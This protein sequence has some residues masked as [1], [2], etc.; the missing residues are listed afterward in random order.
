VRASIKKTV[1][2]TLV[3]NEDEAQYLK[4]LTQNS[5]TDKG[6][7]QSYDIRNQIFQELSHCLD[8]SSN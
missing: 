6:S 2:V 8:S 3:L 4:V 1:E 5:L 7:Q